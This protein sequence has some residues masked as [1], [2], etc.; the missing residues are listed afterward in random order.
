MRIRAAI[1]LCAVQFD[2]TADSDC[3]S[4]SLYTILVLLTFGPGNFSMTGDADLGVIPPTTPA[5]IGVCS[6]SSDPTRLAEGRADPGSEGGTEGGREG[7][8]S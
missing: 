6:F 2:P 7:D 1:Y 4:A 3:S 5:P 8:D